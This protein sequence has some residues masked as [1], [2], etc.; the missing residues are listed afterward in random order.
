ML[1]IMTDLLEQIES[2]DPELYPPIKE[3]C[4]CAKKIG[5]I[6]DLWLRRVW[7]VF[8][9]FKREV[10]E[11]KIAMEYEK[12]SGRQEELSDA[13]FKAVYQNDLYKRLFWHLVRE[14]YSLWR[15]ES[16]SICKG[17]IIYDNSEHHDVP[18]ILRK[19]MD[20]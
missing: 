2:I 7:C 8:Q 5:V 17:W 3:P 14:Q 13:F 10:Q 19:L 11:T 16:L 15:P 20:L 18:S 6:E 1:Q 4:S 12:D 9:S